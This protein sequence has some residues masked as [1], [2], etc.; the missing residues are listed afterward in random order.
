MNED[1]SPHVTAV[2][3]LWVD[4]N[5]WFQ[6][7]SGT[8][9][10]RNV[11]RDPRCSIVV[12]ILDADVV[13]EGEATRETDPASLTR[14]GQGL[15]GPGVARRARR[16]P[17][18]YHRPVQRTLTGPAS[19]ERLSHQATFDDRDTR[20]RAGRPDSLQV[21]TRPSE[22]PI[23]RRTASRRKECSVHLEPSHHR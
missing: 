9:K 2:G 12:S 21:L 10:G 1:G 19:M 4:G 23:R 3:A 20:H 8:R 13:A 18:R 5:F 7:G 15:D 22:T 11:V 6:T 16:E 14:T 17:D